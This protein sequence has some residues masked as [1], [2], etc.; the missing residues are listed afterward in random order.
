M[1]VRLTRIKW[2]A[3]AKCKI[4]TPSVSVFT[5]HVGWYSTEVTAKHVNVDQTL[6][7]NEKPRTNTPFAK[8]LFLGEYDKVRTVNIS[9]IIIF[10]LLG[11][12][13]P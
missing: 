11:V 3:F 8:N 5:S 9:S 13:F 1:A 2:S 7:K 10:P 12:H 6:G 4:D